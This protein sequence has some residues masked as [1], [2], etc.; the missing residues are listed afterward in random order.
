MGDQ[1]FE[2]QMQYV[3]ELSKLMRNNLDELDDRI[4][5]LQKNSQTVNGEVKFTSDYVNM[6]IRN[7]ITAAIP[8]SDKGS[9][10]IDGYKQAKLDILNKLD[11]LFPR[12]E[13]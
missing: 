9:W 3:I 2:F 1:T 7:A 10:Y 11:F 12:A 5:N 13:W 4:A 6:M 8:L